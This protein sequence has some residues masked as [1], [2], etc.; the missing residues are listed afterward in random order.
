MDTCA[1]IHGERNTKTM[2]PARFEKIGPVLR[3]L[4]YVFEVI[5]D[6]IRYN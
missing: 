3:V 6:I 5:E 2:C 1:H 4:E